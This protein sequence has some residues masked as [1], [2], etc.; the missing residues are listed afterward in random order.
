MI[1]CLLLDSY[2][3]LSL[4]ATAFLLLY[5]YW[6]L[7][8]AATATIIWFS[9]GRWNFPPNIS[10]HAPS[11]HKSHGVCVGPNN[12]QRALGNVLPMTQSCGLQTC[13]HNNKRSKSDKQKPQEELSVQLNHWHGTSTSS[14]W[15]GLTSQEGPQP[16]GAAR[17][18]RLGPP[19]PRAPARHK[20]SLGS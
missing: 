16:R 3:L 9:S 18:R 11:K 17:W 14:M 4:A 13:G 10:Q 20:N 1:L 7:A 5:S 15:A 8:L 19:T 12:V 2:W 6:L